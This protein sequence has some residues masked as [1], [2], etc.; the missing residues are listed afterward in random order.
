MS[1]KKGFAPAAPQWA[2]ELAGELQSVGMP[3]DAEIIY[4]GRNRVG[5]VSRG[6]HSL[7]IK[8]FRQPNVVNRYV[9]TTLRRS[10]ARRSLE[11]ACRLLAMGFATP[12]PYLWLEKRRGL[13]LGLSYYVCEEVAG[14]DL[15][16]LD[17]NPD[18]P[19]LLPA[20]AAEM[21]RLHSAGVWHKDFSPGNVLYTPAAQGGFTFHYIDLNRMAFGVKSRRKL[22][23]NFGMLA[24]RPEVEQI[25]R[26]YAPHSPFGL[27]ASE[28]AGEASAA[29][30]RFLSTRPVAR[31][32]RD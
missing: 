7:I 14:R 31:T 28:A 13:C 12:A 25:A 10:K 29:R 32:P 11:N 1:I 4:A 6:G 22:L 27:S 2:R 15:R 26:L 19:R 21:G 20:L 24:P 18:T 5:R 16:F 8:E 17:S 9:Y 23:S 30:T 3:A